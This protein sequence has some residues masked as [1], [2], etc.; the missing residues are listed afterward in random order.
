MSLPFAVNRKR[1]FHFVCNLVPM[2][3][4][5]LR[6]KGRGDFVRGILDRLVLTILL[7]HY[8]CTGEERCVTRKKLIG[9]RLLLL[10]NE[11][12]YVAQYPDGRYQYPVT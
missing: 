6:A 11:I 7:I 2:D 4:P 3:L 1:L 12:Q 10:A 8:Y 5:K 9:G